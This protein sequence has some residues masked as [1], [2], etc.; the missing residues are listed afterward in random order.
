LPTRSRTSPKCTAREEI[1][2]ARVAS[3]G[4]HD[5]RRREHRQREAE[6]HQPGA[7]GDG[8]E[9][10]GRDRRLAQE[11]AVRAK[12]L[13]GVEERGRHEPPEQDSAEQEERIGPHLGA[14][15]EDEPEDGRVDEQ[16]EQRVQERPEETERAAA[17]SRRELALRQR[18]DERPLPEGPDERREKARAVRRFRRQDD[19]RKS[20]RYSR[21]RARSRRSADRC[22]ASSTPGASETAGTGEAAPVTAAPVSTAP[23]QIAC[24]G[25]RKVYGGAEPVVALDGVDLDVAPG[26]FLAVLGPSGG[27]KS[28]LLHLLGGIDRPTSGTVSV[29]GREV[30]AMS[31]GDLTLYRRRDVG[32]VFQFFNLLPHLSVSENVELPRLLDGKKD[33]GSRASDLLARV[34]LSHRAAAHPYELSGGEM[35]RVAIARAL[36][37]GARL[38]LADEPTGNLDSRNGDQVLALLDEIRTERGVTL[39]LATHAESAASRASR[40]IEIHDGRIRA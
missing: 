24:R 2:R 5:D 3:N 22:R 39:I 1:A 37:T 36:V 28:T 8:R 20:I 12:S 25:L 6:V 16:Q 34:G 18:D 9:D 30:A 14:G 15:R 7:G 32:M 10:L 21:G 35:Q 40:R 31:E 17:V 23:P 29:G 38:L 27:G 13:R 11:R 19:G 4:G 33:A 26:E